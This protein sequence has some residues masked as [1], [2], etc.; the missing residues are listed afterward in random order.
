MPTV[1]ETVKA[2]VTIRESYKE[3]VTPEELIEF[4]RQKMAAYKYPRIVEIVSELA[5]TLSGKLLKR[6]LREEEA[7]KIRN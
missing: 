2:F 3:E 7:Q 6:Q 5:K 4:C 1:G